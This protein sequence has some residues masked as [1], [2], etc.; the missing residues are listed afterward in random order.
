[1]GPAER[2]L[3]S[4]LRA[5]LKIR[6]NLIP[7]NCSQDIHQ[8]MWPGTI[9]DAPWTGRHFFNLRKGGRHYDSKFTGR[10]N[11]YFAKPWRSDGYFS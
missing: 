1:M 4:R 7:Y 2:E 10:D 11:G 8:F 3:I 6:Q 9:Y 5:L